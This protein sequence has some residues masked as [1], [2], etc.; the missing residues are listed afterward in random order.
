MSPGISKVPWGAK[1]PSLRII[2]L[3]AAAAEPSAGRF[4]GVSL[5]WEFQGQLLLGDGWHFPEFSPQPWAQHGS[6]SFVSVLSARHSLT[7][8]LLLLLPESLLSLTGQTAES[9]TLPIRLTGGGAV[10]RA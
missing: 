6:L 3:E 5:S 7:F 4:L 1:L 9:L 2:V 8:H 10:G